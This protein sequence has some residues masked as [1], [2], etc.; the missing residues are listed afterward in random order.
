MSWRFHFPIRKYDFNTSLRNLIGITSCCNLCRMVLLPSVVS[1]EKTIFF[2][3]TNYIHG[4]TVFLL[5][6]FDTCET[7]L[8]GI[9]RS[10][11]TFELFCGCIQT[12][13]L[14]CLTRSFLLAELCSR[15]NCAHGIINHWWLQEVLIRESTRTKATAIPP[16]FLRIS[17]VTNQRRS[18]EDQQ[19]MGRRNW[20]NKMGHHTLPIMGIHPYSMKQ[21]YRTRFN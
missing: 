1:E 7:R 17:H 3:R 14:E 4:L 16:P 12:L 18:W 15:F 9:V 21:T 8:Q 2:L 13:R 20:E 19:G 6:I 10:L 5:G 11:G